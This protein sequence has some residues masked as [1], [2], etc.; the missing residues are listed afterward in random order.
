MK[1]DEHVRAED[2]LLDRP[3]TVRGSHNSPHQCSHSRDHAQ[4]RFHTLTESG[5][6]IRLEP[7]SFGGVGPPALTTVRCLSRCGV[8][9][10][11]ASVLRAQWSAGGRNIKLPSLTPADVVTKTLY[12]LTGM[13][14]AMITRFNPPFRSQVPPQW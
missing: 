10:L 1:T 14:R 9:E 5:H 8:Q 3:P 6:R 11:E 7:L 4:A 13:A 2:E 12:G